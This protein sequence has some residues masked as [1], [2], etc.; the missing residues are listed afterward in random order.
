MKF[1]GI[2][3]CYMNDWVL[4]YDKDILIDAEKIFSIIG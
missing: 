4:K 3:T 1:V 2:K